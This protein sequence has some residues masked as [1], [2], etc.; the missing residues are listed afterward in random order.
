MSERRQYLYKITP[1]RL[2]MLTEGPTPREQELVASHFAYL[3]DLTQRGIVLLAG[4]TLNAD[5]DTFGIIIFSAD[6]DD[7]ARQIMADDPAV[8]QG[9]FHAKL[10]PYRVALIAGDAGSIGDT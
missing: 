6:D 1:S 7:Q 4:R 9:V 10:Y 8:R 2:G 3:S 5:T